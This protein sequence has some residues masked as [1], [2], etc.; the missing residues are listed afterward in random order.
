V[1]KVRYQRRE[2]VGR[3]KRSEASEGVRNNPII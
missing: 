3:S 2:D 1:P